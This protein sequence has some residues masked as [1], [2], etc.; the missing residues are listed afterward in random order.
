MTTDERAL[1]LDLDPSAIQR[2]GRHAVDFLADWVRELDSAPASDYGQAAHLVTTLR[3]PPG[4]GPGDFAALLELF[5][6]AAGQ[7]VD[8]AGQ[9]YLAYFPAGGLVTAALAEL[10]ALTVNRFTGVAQV[11]PALVAMEHGVLTWFCDRFGLPAGSGG[12][13]TTGASV[14][15]LSAL[16]AARHSHGDGIL[17]VTEHTHYC[18]A[19]AARIAGLPAE[20]IRTVPATADLRMDVSAA[21]TMIAADRA[22]GLHPFLLVGTAGTTSSGTIDPLPELGELARREGLWF[23]VDAAYGGGFQLT[24]RG[25]DRLAGI[26]AA[27]SIA[28]DPHKSLFLPYGTGLLLVRDPAVLH[29]AHAAD[30]RYLQ[31][32]SPV[33]DLPDFGHLGVELTREFRGL[34]LWLPLHLHGVRAFERELDEKLNLAAHLHNRLTQDSRFEVPWQPDLT[35][36]LFRLRG[37]DED[38]RR[39]LAEINA[40]RRVYLSSTTIDGRFFLR[41]CVLSFRTHADRVEEALAI[42]RSAC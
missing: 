3:R 28:L 20:R 26:E 32:L 35:V 24:E 22:A 41:V 33:D 25:R 6:Q 11:A 34:R 27:D 19:K 39:L 42:I 15:T 13:V 29:A 12:L 17:Y 10:L 36:V 40:G 31:D 9:G 1:P 23:H 4:D 5:R 8:T 30:A 16:L 38:N 2:L 7:G 21:A 37:T 14:A 18:V